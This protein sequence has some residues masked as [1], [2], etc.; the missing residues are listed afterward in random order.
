[1]N[2]A[3]LTVIYHETKEHFNAAINTWNSF[4]KEREIFA[5]TNRKLEG[6]DY[7]KSIKYIDNDRNILARGWN[8]G[9]QEIFKKYDYTIV[10][11]LDLQSPSDEQLLS[12]INEL[13]KH[14]EYGVIGANNWDI[15]SNDNVPLKHGDGSF[16]LYVISKKTFKKVGKF[17]EGYLRAYFEDSDYTERLWQSGFKPIKMNSVKYW[18]YVQGTI[19]MS[20]EIRKEYPKFM[21]KNLELFKK[22]YGKV[23]DHLPKDIKFS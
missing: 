17:N 6:V 13:D 20:D 18:H 5:V 19:K 22:T 7:P 21:Q 2:Y 4:P 15:Q 10:S 12:M 11:N 8:L 9:L 3:I 1:M 23:P 14:P 16:S